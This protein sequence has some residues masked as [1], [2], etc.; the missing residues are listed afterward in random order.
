MVKSRCLALLALPW[1]A[2][3]IRVTDEDENGA[4]ISAAGVGD[5]Q[6]VG[7][8][9]GSFV[10]T[11]GEDGD[12][13]VRKDMG[14]MDMPVEDKISSG[15]QGGSGL[16]KSKVGEGEDDDMQD[17]VSQEAFIF[18]ISANTEYAPLDGANLAVMFEEALSAKLSGFALLDANDLDSPANWEKIKSGLR[19]WTGV[20]KMPDV[21]VVGCQECHYPSDMNNLPGSLLA[22]SERL[23]VRECAKKGRRSLLSYSHPEN[24]AD[25]Q[26]EPSAYSGSL[27]SKMAT[28]DVYLVRKDTGSSTMTKFPYKNMMYQAILARSDSPLAK[29]TYDMRRSISWNKGSVLAFA[30][31][32]DEYGQYVVFGSTHLDAKK[33]SVRL[34]NIKKIMEDIGKVTGDVPYTGLLYGDMN[35]RLHA[36]NP[37]GGSPDTQLTQAAA[38]KTDVGTELMQTQ[39]IDPKMYW[40]LFSNDTLQGQEPQKMY[41]HFRGIDSFANSWPG[42][43]LRQD[44]WEAPDY[45]HNILPTYKIKGI[46]KKYYEKSG[47]VS[48]IDCMKLRA[49]M[50]KNKKNDKLGEEDSHLPAESPQKAKQLL[51]ED[52]SKG[53]LDWE[54]CYNLPK[55]TKPCEAR[56][57]TKD[58]NNAATTCADIGW[59]DR[60]FTKGEMTVLAH[61][62]LG[63]SGKVG[64]EGMGDHS[65][66]HF[67]AKF[68][69]S[70][71][72]ATASRMFMHGSKPVLA[73]RGGSH[74]L[75]GD[76]EDED[77]VPDTFMGA[78][79]APLL[80]S[81]RLRED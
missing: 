53:E 2:P 44:G 81:R 3:G 56:S 8:L 45:T 51:G 30:D 48:P 1:L 25:E 78:P 60:A 41:N 33:P 64:P 38:K 29:A 43:P 40:T 12:G 55:A 26:L 67:A 5:P 77:A 70:K 46:M 69:L 7:G 79:G 80:K 39:Q 49:A 59:L 22:C 27:H 13:E 72:G 10:P 15:P 61:T 14:G 42:N 34:G 37:E 21:I 24:N 35:Y 63:W 62:T 6:D 54:S 52:K 73:K 66:F 11:D 17:A 4:A 50:W 75:L 31:L 74:D 18:T 32:R 9:D 57:Q 19:Q 36:L 47:G 28:G 20:D 71:S 58:G 16:A 23:G 68:T 65:P 76:L